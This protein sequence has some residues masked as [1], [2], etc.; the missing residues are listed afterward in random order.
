[1]T[2]A[3]QLELPV[4]RPSI[5]VRFMRF[6][7]E[8]PQVYVELRTL[9]RALAA[10]GHRHLGISMLWETLRYNAALRL[11]PPEFDSFKLNNDFR[12]R[13]VRLLISQEPDLADLFEVRELRSR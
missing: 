12:S 9:A 7:R 2:H 13:Y 5:D 10:G 1:M 3:Q 11:T 8:N 4:Q 6:H